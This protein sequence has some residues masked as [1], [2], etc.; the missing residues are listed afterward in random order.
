MTALG[1]GSI[2]CDFRAG[3]YPILWAGGYVVVTSGVIT[4][5]GANTADALAIAAVYVKESR[6]ATYRGTMDDSYLDGAVAEER[7]R[8]WGQRMAADEPPLVVVGES[9]DRIV[10][11][12]CAF[13]AEDPEW[14]TR[15]DNLHALPAF[16]W[17]YDVDS[18]ARA[19]YGVLG[20]RVMEKGSR[21][22][23]DG[24]VSM[25]WRMIWPALLAIAAG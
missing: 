20:G 19:A 16:L 13:P 6:R 21:T 12:T 23:V 4:K 17:V 1:I 24:S 10:G 5:R 2:P 25:V 3:P 11:F 18:A 15:N 7:A 9:D 8:T 14:G 22:G